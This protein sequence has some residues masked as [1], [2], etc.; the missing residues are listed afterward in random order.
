MAFRLVFYRPYGCFESISSVNCQIYWQELCCNG[1]DR[2]NCNLFLLLNFICYILP[3]DCSRR[4]TLPAPLFFQLD[5]TQRRRRKCFPMLWWRLR[6]E[7]SARRHCVRPEKWYCR[8][9]EQKNFK[10]GVFSRRPAWKRAGTF[11]LGTVSKQESTYYSTTPV[12][13]NF[14]S[15]SCRNFPFRSNFC[16]FLPFLQVDANDQIVVGV[17]SDSTVC[18][19]DRLTGN[20][21]GFYPIFLSRASLT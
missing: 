16:P 13:T 6:Y 1:Q 12:G 17:S 2:L 21:K 8:N 3:K 10:E 18:V 5:D 11:M 19:W 15:I 14:L 7:N 20:L 4:L 9:M